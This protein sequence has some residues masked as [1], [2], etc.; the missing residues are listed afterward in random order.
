MTQFSHPGVSVVVLNWNGKSLLAECLPSV[1]EA[2]TAYSGPCEV[3]VVD[4][5]STDDSVAF[6]KNTFPSVNLS[7]LPENYHFQIGCNKGVD[8]SKYDFIV[9]L[10]NDVAVD[11]GFIKPLVNHLVNNDNIFSVAPKMFYW[12]REKVYCSAII[13]NFDK[14]R[15]IQ[16]W[17][18][19]AEYHDLCART[20]P[21]IYTSG[22]AMAFKKQVFNALGQFD[23]L[24]F[25]IYWEDADI[26]YQAWKRGLISLYEPLSVVYHKVSATM[27]VRKLSYHFL[28][29]RNGYLFT[30]RNV[31][32]PGILFTHI[33]LLM[34]NLF[35]Y[36]TGTARW[37]KI[38]WWQAFWIEL[39]SFF[40]ALTRL[41]KVASRRI[42]DKKFQ[43]LS[44]KEVLKQSDWQQ[45]EITKIISNETSLPE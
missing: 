43:A 16:S 39:K 13:G 7:E 10:N 17:A 28:M 3:L 34:P 5:G 32:D 21:T 41:P 45:N 8:A 33:V 38:N 26:C 15:F 25:P 4:N 18:L 27:M 9:L 29:Q 14:G 42:S 35:R 20:A 24:Y 44:D 22:G 30:W 40:A 23:L 6:V 1:V 12:D 37:F 2:A 31:T 11:K 19:D 36:A